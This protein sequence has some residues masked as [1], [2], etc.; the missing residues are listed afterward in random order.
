[1]PELHPD[2]VRLSLPADADLRTVVEVAVAVV[3]RR[4][5]LPDAEVSA[6]RNA[7][8]DVFIELIGGGGGDPV[9]LE[10][11]VEDRRMVGRFRVGGT[12]RQVTAPGSI[13]ASG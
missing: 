9:E 10:L 6:A 4:L 8:G 13:N 11:A 12:E 3:A 7:A 5:G 1:M 2:P